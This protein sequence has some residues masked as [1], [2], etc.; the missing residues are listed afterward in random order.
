MEQRAILWVS[1]NHG[2]FFKENGEDITI[3]DPYRF[4]IG[5]EG[6]FDHSEIHGPLEHAVELV[7]ASL[8]SELMDKDRALDSLR[9][10]W[11]EEIDD[12]FW[13]LV[14]TDE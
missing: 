11:P 5:V 1:D 6:K 2:I 12:D 7:R 4:Y 10:D 9:I 3:Y 14:W 13:D 8:V